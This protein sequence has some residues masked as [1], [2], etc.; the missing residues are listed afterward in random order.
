MFG[1]TNVKVRPNAKKSPIYYVTYIE[2]TGTQWIDTEYAIKNGD[3]VE[4]CF[5]ATSVPSSGE[6]WVYATWG[7][8]PAYFRCGFSNS[9]FD[10]TRGFTYSQTADKTA[11][12]I[13]IGKSTVDTTLTAY[14]FS[15][16]E[17][18][19]A[20]HTANSKYKLYYCKIYN[21]GGSLVH[22]FRPCR[23]DS[24]VY[25]L[26]DEVLKAYFYNAGSGSFT[27]GASI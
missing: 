3:T 17:S 23:D 1:K 15:Q 26:Y 16:H 21:S 9:A 24:G 5:Q 7:S 20:V 22:D 8:D 19:G 18:S 25:C 11:K 12:T 14:L 6:S 13:G 27:G 10:T 4:I 2:S